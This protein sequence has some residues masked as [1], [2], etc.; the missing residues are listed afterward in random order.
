MLTDISKHVYKHIIENMPLRNLLP[1]S[2]G[3]NRRL[4]NLHNTIQIVAIKLLLKI[5]TTY[6]T[7]RNS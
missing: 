2:K 7:V 4:L 3:Q 6:N 5:N 1:T